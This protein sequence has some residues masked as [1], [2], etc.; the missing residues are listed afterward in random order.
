MLRGPIQDHR[1]QQLAR[2]T[3]DKTVVN[4]NNNVTILTN[5]HLFR[6]F[7]LCLVQMQGN[8]MV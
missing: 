1:W 3:M 6:L 7:Q 8:H 2:K 5:S 4:L